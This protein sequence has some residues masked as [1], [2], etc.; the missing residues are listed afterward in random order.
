[1][2][3]GSWRRPPPWSRA[4][5]VSRSTLVETFATLIGAYWLS[6]QVSAVLDHLLVALVGAGVPLNRGQ[7]RAVRVLATHLFWAASALHVLGSRLR[8]F[9]PPAWRRA[10]PTVTG[11]GVEACTDGEEGE[12]A[13]APIGEAHA[14]DER[15]GWF[16]LSWR[17]PWLRWVLGGYF[18][19]VVGYNALDGACSAL[20]PPRRRP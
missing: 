7:V 4:A 1:M 6:H 11:T 12:A 16:S 19:S 10:Q 2:E 15:P 17:G 5:P 18:A 13:E 3:A 20:L 8:P 9:F 14:D